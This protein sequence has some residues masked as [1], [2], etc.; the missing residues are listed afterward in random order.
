MKFVV[1]IKQYKCQLTSI[2][3]R[4]KKHKLITGK[5]KKKD[6]RNQSTIA[7]IV[8]A[9]CKNTGCTVPKHCARIGTFI[10]TSQGSTCKARAIH[11][12]KISDYDQFKILFVSQNKNKNHLIFKIHRDLH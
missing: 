5:K 6:S 4:K 7:T 2:F 11:G 10:I 12:K 8:C 1:S 3:K 9:Q